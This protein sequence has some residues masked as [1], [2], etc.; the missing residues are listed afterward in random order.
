MGGV[1]R[2]SFRKNLIVITGPTASGKSEFAMRLSEY[3][4]IEIISADS[5]QVFK[6]MDIGTAKP[7]VDD[8]KSVKHHFIDNKKPDEYY[9]SGLFGNEANEKVNELLS[10]GK[11][12]VVVGGSGLYIKSLCEGFFNEEKDKRLFEIRSDLNKRLIKEGV[13]NLYNELKNIDIES[14]NLYHEKNPRRIIRALEYYYW[15]G[16]N[17]SKSQADKKIEGRKFNP[18]YYAI[19]HHREKLYERINQ[20]V[21]K[22]IDDGLVKEVESILMH[23]YDKNL[24]SLNTVGYK[25]IIRYLDGGLDLDTAIKE[26]QKNTRRFAKRQLTWF[27]GLESLNWIERVNYSEIILE[28]EKLVER[29]NK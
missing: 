3:L 25:E 24:N 20:R 17:F 26:V 18:V 28:I 6:Y 2:N 1:K 19:S 13:D 7:G 9:S 23:P 15:K 27:R 12:P 5:R 21:I 11:T 8:L 4:D 29:N 10:C 22:M 14:Y 16:E